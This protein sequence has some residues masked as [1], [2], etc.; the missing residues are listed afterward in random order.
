MRV[1]AIEPGQAEGVCGRGVIMV[2]VDDINVDIDY[3]TEAG[4][5]KA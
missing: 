4:R 5:P 2:H 3:D 1:L